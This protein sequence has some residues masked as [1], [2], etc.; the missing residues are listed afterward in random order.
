MSSS[1]ENSFSNDDVSN[2]AIQM[3]DIESRLDM[4]TRNYKKK[5]SEDIDDCQA[6]SN[7]KNSSNSS[8]SINFISSLTKSGSTNMK[9]SYNSLQN[10]NDTLK[11]ENA[12][13]NTEDIGKINSKVSEETF[14]NRKRMMRSTKTSSSSNKKEITIDLITLP[15]TEHSRQLIESNYSYLT[16]RFGDEIDEFSKL[17]SEIKSLLSEEKIKEY[18]REDDYN[19]FSFGDE[20]LKLYQMALI[21]ELE[22]N[23]KKVRSLT[24]LQNLIGSLPVLE[25]PDQLMFSLAQSNAPYYIVSHAKI[26]VKP[27]KE[28]NHKLCK[29]C[30][31]AKKNN[32]ECDCSCANGHH[33]ANAKNVSENKDDDRI[34]NCNFCSCTFASPQGLGGHM[35]RTHKSQSIKYLKKK[36]IR[37]IREPLRKLL[38]DSKKMLCNNHNKDYDMLIKTKQG[39]ESIKKLIATHQKEYKSIKRNLAQ[40]IIYTKKSN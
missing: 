26:P 19:E 14:L 25:A 15:Q 34:Y 3:K 28:L 13:E 32:K 17:N 21:D 37:E 8:S 6:A 40:S 20:P 29:C 36:E 22:G 10:S 1:E 38:E 5:Q 18:F 9:T 31:I 12:K 27:K 33:N 2:G 30:G 7:S 35:S 11:E 23:R 24:L 16:E 4:I 39:K